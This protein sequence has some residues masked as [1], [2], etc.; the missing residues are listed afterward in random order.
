[1]KENNKMINQVEIFFT[2]LVWYL[3]NLFLSFRSI[4]KETKNEILFRYNVSFFILSLIV[5]FKLILS[6][7]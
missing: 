5:G 2:Y 4:S 1:M 3:L 6:W 7:K